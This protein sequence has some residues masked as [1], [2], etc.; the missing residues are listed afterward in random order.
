MKILYV[1]PLGQ[2]GLVKA[3]LVQ[4]GH[5]VTC[6]TELDEALDMIATQ[7]FSAVLIAEEVD[8]PEVF[9]FISKVHRERPEVLVFQLSVWRSELAETLEMVEAMEQGGDSPQA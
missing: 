8:D 9:E 1:D 2:C 4:A 7:C 5:R 3:E 6:A